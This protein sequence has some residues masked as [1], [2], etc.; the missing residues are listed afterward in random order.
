M[1]RSRPW[2]AL[3]LHARGR[4]SSQHMGVLQACTC[5]AEDSACAPEEGQGSGAG[6][7]LICRE[8]WLPGCRNRHLVGPPLSAASALGFSICYV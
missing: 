4:N 2:R 8:S 7:A 3:A 6:H 5:T 1:Q